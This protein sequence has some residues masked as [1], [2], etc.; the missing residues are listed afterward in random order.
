MII[1]IM[2]AVYI[3]YIVQTLLAYGTYGL[4]SPAMSLPHLSFLPVWI[5][6]LQ[7]VIFACVLRLI[8]LCGVG[9]VAANIG[10]GNSANS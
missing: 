5:N 9:A 10:R 2:C 3:P 6:G 7:A 8:A 1:I 4:S